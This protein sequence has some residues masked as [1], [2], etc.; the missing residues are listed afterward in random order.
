MRI[1]NLIENTEGRAGC[2]NEH[3]LSFYIETEKH[4][5]LMDLGQT[6]NSLR[7]AKELGVDL[8]AVDTVV[9]SHGHYDHS[10]GIM[11][12]AGINDHAII[13]M[14]QSAGG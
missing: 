10:G 14:Q 13:Y 8:E 5:L 3:G 12:F 1:I 2:V 6:D 4:K 9:L 7:N 11:P